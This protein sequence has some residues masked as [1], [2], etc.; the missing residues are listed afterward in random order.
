MTLKLAGTRVKLSFVSASASVPVAMALVR[1]V[2][3]MWGASVAI[4]EV[5]YPD[6]PLCEETSSNKLGRGP[7]AKPG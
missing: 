6:S 5:T 2:R 1:D 3:I 7:L 4:W